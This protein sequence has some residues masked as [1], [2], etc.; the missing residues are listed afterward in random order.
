MQNFSVLFILVHCVGLII[1]SV[2][3]IVAIEIINVDL[4]INSICEMEKKLIND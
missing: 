1:L 2:V 3:K 4:C